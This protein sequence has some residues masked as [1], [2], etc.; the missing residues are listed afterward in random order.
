[1]LITHRPVASQVE[2]VFA[3]RLASP[4]S[5]RER[6]AQRVL[7]GLLGAE[8]TT[9]IR[10]KAGATYS[11]SGGAGAL[12]A[13]GAHLAVTMSVDTRRLR[14]ALRVL[15]AE[16]DE[17]AA[18]RIDKGAVSQI[19]WALAGD[20]ALDY[21]TGANTAGQ[22]LRAFMFDLPLAT[23][24]TDPDELGRVSEHDVARAFA[25]CVSSRVLSL[26]GDEPTIRAAM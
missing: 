23:L 19:Q 24:V 2:V 16:L 9:E 21:Q 3:C 12:P 8:L 7:A 13:G 5:G 17:L 10:E 1:V 22:I 20:D 26:V 4:T 14:D 25:P 6:A 18:G 15:H 11:V